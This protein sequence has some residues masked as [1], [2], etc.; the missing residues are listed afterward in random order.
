MRKVFMVLAGALI[1][2]PIFA[3]QKKP[4]V[5]PTPSANRSTNLNS[6][7]SN[8][9]VQPTVTPTLGNAREVALGGPDTAAR[10][11]PTKDQRQMTGRVLSQQGR[12]FTVLSN[13]KEFTFF[14]KAGEIPKVGDTIDITYTQ[15][16]DGPLTVTTIKSTK[17]NTS[18]RVA[19]VTPTPSVERG[20]PTKDQ[21]Q[22]TGKV[23]R[24]SGNTFTVLSGGKEVTFSAA[25]TGDYWQFPK[26]GETIDITYTQTPGG[27]LE[28][29]TVRGSK[30]NSDN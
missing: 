5:T 4:T 3:Q 7:K 17:S 15:T 29:V 9:A 1:A 16:P 23:I 8:R 26:V 10:G 6:S 30:S 28:A 14:A 22:M 27:P 13:G 21:R 18:D 11:K 20:K 25:K 19:E 12:T 24:Q 2:L